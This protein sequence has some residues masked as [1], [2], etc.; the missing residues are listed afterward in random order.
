MA[1]YQNPIFERA[2][3][4]LVEVTAAQA[5]LYGSVVPHAPSVQTS[6]TVSGVATFASLLWNLAQKWFV[7]YRSARL[8]SLAAAIDAAVAAR[9]AAQ[10]NVREATPK[11]DEAPPVVETSPGA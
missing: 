10:V 3:K 11:L 8:D 9:L 2:Y 4:T 6:A 5:A 1:F 7:N